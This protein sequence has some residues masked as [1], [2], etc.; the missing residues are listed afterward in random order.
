[1]LE[2]EL[3]SFPD[4]SLTCAN[5]LQKFHVLIDLEEHTHMKTLAKKYVLMYVCVMTSDVMDKLYM[6]TQYV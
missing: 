4:R 6:H 3:E 2:E 1:M 5:Y